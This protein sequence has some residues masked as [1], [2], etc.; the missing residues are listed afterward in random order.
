M[1]IAIRLG[2]G[3]VFEVRDAVT[4]PVTRM[5]V[6]GT[7]TVTGT[8]SESDSEIHGKAAVAASAS[9]PASRESGTAV[10]VRVTAV[11]FKLL[12]ACPACY[13]R[14]L[15]PSGSES[16]GS[17]RGRRGVTVLG[18]SRR[19]RARAP[20][21]PGPGDASG[22]KP[23]GPRPETRLAG[24]KRKRAIDQTFPFQC[25][26]DAASPDGAASPRRRRPAEAGPRAGQWEPAKY[27]LVVNNWDICRSVCATEP[28]TVE[29]GPA[30]G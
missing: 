21:P 11:G 20:G 12:R 10:T 2:E 13:Y 24:Y 30:S 4:V 18:P 14:S 23:E 19:P 1:T 25:S 3:R 26:H 8:C 28:F 29:P 6:P 9:G 16:A 17:I 27:N 22:T 7:H 15:R 5:A